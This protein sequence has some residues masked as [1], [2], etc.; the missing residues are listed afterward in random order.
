MKLPTFANPPSALALAITALLAAASAQAANY[1]WDTAPG[2]VGSGNSTITGGSG[3]WDTTLGNWTSDAGVNNIAWS[4]TT[5][6]TA[7][8]GG[9]AGVVNLGRNI[10]AT[11]LTFNTTGYEVQ[12]AYSL[13]LKGAGIISA[14]PGTTTTI[15]STISGQVGLL[16][17]GDGI[18]ILATN[19]NYTGDTSISAGT[20]RLDNNPALPATTNVVISAAGTLDLNG[21]L[22]TISGLSGSGLVTNSNSASSILTVDNS[23]ATSTFS[24]VIEN[25]SGYVS[26]T[27]AGAGTLILSGANSYSGVTTISSG[28]LSVGSIGNGGVAGNLGKASNAAG[29]LVFDGGTLQY[30]GSTNSTNRN[31]TISDG[32]AAIIEIRPGGTNLTISGA[33]TEDGVG[34]LTKTGAG[35][36]TLAGSNIYSGDTTISGGTLQLGNGGTT[37]SLAATS[38]I[39]DEATLT[40][41]RSNTLTQGTGFN[42]VISGGGAVVQAGSGTTILTGGNT[43]TGTTTI[44]AGTLSVNTLANGGVTSSIGSSSNDA[45]NLVFD[46]GTL[47][48]TG[49]TVSTDR[50]F[51]I[52]SGKVGTIEVTNNTLTISGAAAATSGGLTKAGASTLILTGTNLY[53]GT[54]TV[55]A[56]V[57]QLGNGGTDGS[58]SASSAIV[59]NASL[60]FNR[61]NLLTQG[62][63]FNSVISGSGSVIQ[64][65]SGTMILTGIN[66]YTGA[67]NVTA[68]SLFINGNNSAATGA[69]TVA[70]GATLG[71]SGTVGGATTVLTG[72][73]HAPGTAPGTVG[74]E[75]F[76][77]SLTYSSGS[78]VKWDL[79]GSALGSPTG[80]DRQGSYDKVAANGVNVISGAVFEVDLAGLDGNGSDFS[81]TFWD[82]HRT[83]S[84]VFTGSGVASMN[85]ELFSFGGS[86]GHGLT[87]ASSGTVAGQ[88]RF[89]FTGSTLNW[90]VGSL[91]PIPEP[92][93]WVV[94]GALVGSGLCLRSRRRGTGGAAAR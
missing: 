73:I 80:I 82:S 43:Y 36:L 33:G 72:G 14:A 48:Y 65:G 85:G 28:T 40:F 27:K 31:F 16:K 12:G 87:V 11:G 56:G 74:T 25:P 13:T 20:L 75:T 45:A 63:D 52:N 23:G 64:A 35:T 62:T 46:G 94:L 8:F 54:T 53:T 2:I 57:L 17:A 9:T 89:Y 34:A 41:N 55:S 50:N 69:V 1:T 18:V 30:T 59:D 81:G 60:E 83:W 15:K 51:T 78:T 32:N 88:G 90:D 91:T 70:A 84:D 93:S 49:S 47:K 24:G 77:S 29:N 58:L 38:A 67:T 68:G 86:D 44:S 7:I 37:G 10:S 42:N 92:G 26:L 66:L 19:S 22:A 61:S 76:S 6:G 3:S 21:R 71:G 5:P 39:V 79:S 4:N